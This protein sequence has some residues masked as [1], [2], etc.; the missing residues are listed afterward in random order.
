MAFVFAVTAKN[1][2]SVPVPI[3]SK[4]LIG[5][6]KDPSVSNQR[7]ADARM[8]RRVRQ[9]GKALSGFVEDDALMIMFNSSSK[10][11]IKFP[12][13]SAAIKWATDKNSYIKMAKNVADMFV[14]FGKHTH[15]AVKTMCSM[16]LNSTF[17]SDVLGLNQ[18]DRRRTKDLERKL[19][20]TSGFEE[21]QQ[22]LPLG[23]T[24]D[25]TADVK[26]TS[27]RT[28]MEEQKLL[29]QWAKNGALG[30]KS[31][32]TRNEQY[33]AYYRRGEFYWDKYRAGYPKVISQFLQTDDG[34]EQLLR[35]QAAIT[36]GG[37][38]SRFLRN[39]AVMNVHGI[40]GIFIKKQFKL[41]VT[42]EGVEAPGRTITASNEIVPPSYTKFYDMLLRS[43]K[44][45]SGLRVTFSLTPKICKPCRELEEWQ[46]DEEKMAA[47][48]DFIDHQC[49]P[50]Y[51]D[52]Q[53]N[54]DESNYA[55]LL[56]HK[57][58]LD[59]QR[60]YVR[61][62]EQNLQEDEALVYIDFAKFYSSSGAKVKDH[63]F[64]V[65]TRAPNGT[66][67]RRYIDCFFKGS[68][69]AAA[70]RY[71]WTDLI[72]NQGEFDGCSRLIITGDTGNGY[73]SWEMLLFYSTWY[74]KYGIEV[75][76][77]F[78]CPRHAHSMCD[79]HGGNVGRHIADEKKSGWVETPAQC[80]NVVSDSMIENTTVYSYAQ[81]DGRDD[82]DRSLRQNLQK[83]LVGIRK[84][85]SFRFFYVDQSG[86]IH[87]EKGIAVGRERS[88]FAGL[89]DK[90]LLFILD[91][92][93]PGCNKCSKNSRWPIA[94][95]NMRCAAWRQLQNHG[96]E[97]RRQSRADRANEIKAQREER[98]RVPEGRNGRD[99]NAVGQAQRNAQRQPV[100]GLAGSDEDWLPSDPN[101][102][103]PATVEM[104][105]SRAR[106][107]RGQAQPIVSGSD[108]EK[109]DSLLCEPLSPMTQ[110]PDEKDD[111]DSDFSWVPEITNGEEADSEM[112][113]D[114][115]LDL[116]SLGLEDDV[117]QL[118][119]PEGNKFLQVGKMVIV[120]P[121]NWD[122]WGIVQI[123]TLPE[124]YGED[125]MVT[126]RCHNC[127]PNQASKQ[128]WDQNRFLEGPIL[129]AWIDV[130]DSKELFSRERPPAGRNS[131]RQWEPYFQKIPLGA[132]VGDLGCFDLG[133]GGKLP[134]TVW[135][136]MMECQSDHS[137]SAKDVSTGKSKKR[138][139]DNREESRRKRTR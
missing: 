128:L 1:V 31:G 101:P 38:T 30:N 105:Q 75:E 94:H 33:Y 11:A 40:D 32:E 48:K 88:G 132:V 17:R 63:I 121:S 42:R 82:Y 125:E 76:L 18:T 106:R 84:L 86:T 78:L 14:Y 25:Y 80:A 57:R 27:E 91:K 44:N 6:S 8:N 115:H 24:R 109:N 41:N 96:E 46:H 29:H 49:D 71:I 51:R 62:K 2:I 66:L 81:I 104:K 74:E 70:T 116:K 21:K 83:D 131:H 113:D 77:D 139:G 15:I 133:A 47:M 72:E 123:T 9:A 55:A 53:L 50:N 100:G 59:C 37:S 54:K 135:N 137:V 130:V 65:V 117:F 69:C 60:D 64:T 79:A 98:K 39:L 136:F 120:W 103:F 67:N 34:Q 5:D 90:W 43:T 56:R 114:G 19:T 97:L 20:N 85:H 7:N 134:P 92:S 28:D 129:P 93:V 10:N 26:R 87:K 16:G 73:R 118:Q 22:M 89:N 23:L 12:R 126:V 4:W 45:P 127:M 61:C 112:D 95:P 13:L 108:S 138:R 124:L 68:S 102:V 36:N 58:V 52:G 35:A 99:R 111:E 119:I 107:V 3:T 110:S 122:N